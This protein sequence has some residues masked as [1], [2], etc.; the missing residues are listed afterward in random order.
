MRK[1]VLLILF[2]SLPGSIFPQTKPDSIKLLVRLDD[3]GLTREVNKAASMILDTGLPLN[4]SVLWP[5]PCWKDAV[6]ILKNYPD[7]IAGVHSDINCEY[8]D[9]KWGPIIGAEK[10]PSLVDSEG[11]FRSDFVADWSKLINPH[12]ME[13]EI[14]AQVKRAEKSGLNVLYIDGHMAGPLYEKKDR[15]IV[16]KIAK[17]YG[18]GVETSFKTLD[19]SVK[20]DLDSAKVIDNMVNT[21][22]NFKPGKLYLMIIHPSLDD[23]LMHN[24]IF[25]SQKEGPGIGPYRYNLVRAFLSSR[26]QNLLKSMPIKLVTYK[27]LIDEE[28]TR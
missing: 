1:L 21:I 18:L 13:Y 6:E 11:Y 9:Y 27:T 24:M 4:V 10:A 28:I 20:D 23:S 7:V 12:E 8:K 17:E 2:L 5:A 19:A 16:E 3:I 25:D 15:E 26:V 22:K 14:K